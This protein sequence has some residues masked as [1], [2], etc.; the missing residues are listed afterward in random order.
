VTLLLLVGLLLFLF[1][2]LVGQEFGDRQT[3]SLTPSHLP[4]LWE[5]FSPQHF[6]ERCTVVFDEL[7]V[8]PPNAGDEDEIADNVRT[9]DRYGRPIRVSS[10]NLL[11]ETGCTCRERKFRPTLGN[12][13]I[14]AC[15]VRRFFDT[16]GLRAWLIEKKLGIRPRT[17]RAWRAGRSEPSAEERREIIRLARQLHPGKY[18]VTVADVWPAD[19]ATPEEQRAI[20]LAERRV[21]GIVEV[22]NFHQTYSGS[23]PGHPTPTLLDIVV[24]AYLQGVHDTV[25]LTTERGWLTPDGA[26]RETVDA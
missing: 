15:R 22:F 17:V 20:A 24:S 5:Y 6:N 8:S 18:P 16:Y 7:A 1:G 13:A 26:P 10:R 23:L 9:V 25:Q 3:P 4:P 12:D 21:G 14:C 19:A 11:D 2:L